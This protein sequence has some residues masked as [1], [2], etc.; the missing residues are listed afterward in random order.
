MAEPE[1]RNW[2][3][4]LAARRPLVFLPSQTMF[5]DDAAVTLDVVLADVVEQ[6]A[7][8]TDQ[9]Q[10]SPPAVMVLDVDLQVLGEVVDAGGQQRDLHL[11]RARIGV[12]QPVGRD[13]LV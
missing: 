4:W 3:Y 9:H 8:L 5:C 11:G 13:R 6:P 10:Q 1:A 7:S 12:M 2:D